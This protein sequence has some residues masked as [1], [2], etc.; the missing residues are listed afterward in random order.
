MKYNLLNSSNQDVS[1]G[2]KF[3]SLVS[4][5][6]YDHWIAGKCCLNLLQKYNF[7]DDFINFDIP[8]Y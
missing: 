7:F 5:Y 3:M 4:L 1:N 6:F 2:G 8:K